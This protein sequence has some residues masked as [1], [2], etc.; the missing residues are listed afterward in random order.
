MGGELSGL[1]ERLDRCRAQ[2]VERLGSND[3]EACRRQA[4]TMTVQDAIR[5]GLEAL[6]GV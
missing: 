3:W 4:D 5:Y 1:G 6:E 2:H